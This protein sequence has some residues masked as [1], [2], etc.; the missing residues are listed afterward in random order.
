MTEVV[1]QEDVLKML[2]FL[3]IKYI[4]ANHQYMTDNTIVVLKGEENFQVHSRLEECG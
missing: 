1:N 4:V 2:E 3:G